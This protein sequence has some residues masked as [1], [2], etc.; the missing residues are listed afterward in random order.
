M[1]NCIS[2][3]TL[4]FSI[5]RSQLHEGSLFAWGERA[6]NLIRVEPGLHELESIQTERPVPPKTFQPA[7]ISK[8]IG[9][10]QGKGII[11]LN[12]T[13]SLTLCESISVVQEYIARPLLISGHKFDLRLYVFVPSTMPLTVYIYDE[14]L[15]R[16]AVEKYDIKCLSSNFSH[17][18]NASLNKLSP[19]Y[20]VDKECLGI[21]CKWTLRRLR[22]YLQSQNR[23]DWFMWQRIVS[24]I[25][26]TL[27]GESVKAGALPHCRNCFEFLGYDILLDDDLRPW[28]LE[29]NHS[30][31]LNADCKVDHDVKNPLLHDLFNL[32][33]LPNHG[34]SVNIFKLRS[35]QFLISF[36]FLQVRRSL[37]TLDFLFRN[38]CEFKVQF[39]DRI[40]RLL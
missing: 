8:P 19:A 35:I 33:G 3:F 6:R 34:K 40:L 31:G 36:L 9:K 22:Q 23:R 2:N 37:Q 12:D 5:I 38:S 10:S 30:P 21:G 11:I 27:V 18:T 28:L 7:W 39:H 17:L 24:I 29:V 32:L 16:F 15:T 20:D 13:S 14:G 4:N 26:L 25:V 1:P